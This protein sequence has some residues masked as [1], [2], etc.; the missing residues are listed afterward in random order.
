MSPP[1]IGIAANPS[2]AGL[3]AAGQNEKGIF[4]KR[5]LWLATLASACTGIAHVAHG[6]PA[7]PHALAAAAEASLQAWVRGPQLREQ[8]AATLGLPD[9]GDASRLRLGQG[10]RMQTLNARSLASNENLA[11]AIEPGDTWRFLLLLDENPVGLATVERT[12]SGSYVIVD[13]GARPFAER[14][15]ELARQ[16]PG[17]GPVSLLRSREAAVDVVAFGAGPAGTRIYIPISAAAYGA[18]A[19]DHAAVAEPTLSAA[20][21]TATLRGAIARSGARSGGSTP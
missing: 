9:A 15:V 14:V 11:Q 13:I 4:M 18:T 20:M 7:A 12:G 1:R 6:A 10:L 17:T 3:H 19:S 5:I 21:L 16:Q 8:I 2:P